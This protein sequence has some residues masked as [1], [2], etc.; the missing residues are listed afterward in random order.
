MLLG[1]ALILTHF[2]LI[3]FES[4]TPLGVLV[5]FESDLETSFNISSC[6]FNRF[7]AILFQVR[8]F[9]KF[10]MFKIYTNDYQMYQFSY[11]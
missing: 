5:F 10:V 2:C 4:S 9:G 7:R 8:V 1:D 3:H 11:D 6:S